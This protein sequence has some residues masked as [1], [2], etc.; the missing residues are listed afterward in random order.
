MSSGCVSIRGR[1]ENL[2]TKNMRK[3]IDIF[4]NFQALECAEI[5]TFVSKISPLVALPAAMD[6]RTGRGGTWIQLG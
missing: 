3:M 1:T 4:L 2:M 5:F 6:T